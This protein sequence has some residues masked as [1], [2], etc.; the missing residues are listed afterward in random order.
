MKGGELVTFLAF[1][2]LHEFMT[3]ACLNFLHRM[4]VIGM[5]QFLHGGP[6]DWTASFIVHSL[7]FLQ[8]AAH[9]SRPEPYSR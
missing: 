8:A 7:L 9:P 6:I 5:W 3:G 4:N 1:K 2:H